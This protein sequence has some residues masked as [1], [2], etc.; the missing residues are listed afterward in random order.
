MPLSGLEGKV[1]VVTGAASGIGRAAVERL[2]DEKALVTMMDVARDRLA[3]SADELGEDRVCSVAGDVS[4]LEDLERAFAAGSD[5]FG[6]VDGLLN[7]AGTVA[8]RVP[9]A[10]IDPGEFD[11]VFDVN[12]RGTFLGMR[13]MLATAAR[14]C[15]PAAI[16]NVASGLAL[17]GSP[18]SGFYA[19]SKAAI[20]SLTQTAALE[21]AGAGV[22]INVLVPG[23][24]DTPLFSRHPPDLRQIV[25]GDVPLGRLGRPP[26]LASAAAW[27]LSDES[28]F[29]TGTALRVDGGEAA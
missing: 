13:V 6:R 21:N 26:E 23:P 25:V 1:F 15:S 17:R 11:R 20:I 22:R 9:L 4:C 2:L 5:R 10:D 12:V 3:Q 7:N 24:V 14:Q 8:P 29:V 19:A 28:S 18:R 27:L 16:V